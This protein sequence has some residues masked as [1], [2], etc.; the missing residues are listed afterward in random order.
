[1]LFINIKSSIYYY[2]TDYLKIRK[3]CINLKQFRSQIYA[4]SCFYLSIVII[5]LPLENKICSFYLFLWSFTI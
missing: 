4:I 1:M 3:N 2:F 5:L